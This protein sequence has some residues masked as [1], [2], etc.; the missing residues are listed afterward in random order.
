MASLKK[1]FVYNL[2]YQILIIILPLITAPYISRVLGAENVGVY[3]YTYSVANYFVLISM[4]GVKNYGNRSIARVRDDKE[5]LSKSFCNI[6]ALQIITSI[7]LGVIYILY[8]L[9]IAKENKIIALIQFFFV[10]TAI[11]DITWFFFGIEEFKITV[12]RNTVIKIVNVICILIFVKQRTDLWKYTLIMSLGMLL[13]YISVFPFLKRWVHFVKPSLKEIKSHFKP[14][15][16][17]FVPVL[18][19]SL[20]NIMDK[21]MLGNL[22]NMTQVGFYENTEKLMRIPFGVITALGTVM[23]PRMSNLVS[24][25]DRETGKKMINYSMVFIMFLANGMTFGLAGVGEIFAPIFFGNEF[26]ACGRLLMYIAPTILCL[27]WANVIRMQYLIPCGM[28]KE[29][30]ISTFVGA[31]VNMTINLILIPHYGAMGAIVGTVCAELSVTLYQTFAVRHYLPIKDLFKATYSFMIFGVVMF[32]I[33]YLIGEIMDSS[34]VT[35]FI[36]IFTGIIIY[37]IISFI[38]L[39]KS[40]QHIITNIRDNVLL[41]LKKR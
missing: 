40:R 30:T 35:L 10:L 16:I 31:G 6:Y 2:L 14:N 20:F 38:Y 7:I 25:G 24:N 27:S 21:I 5:E 17:L 18:A 33:V 1:N 41:K 15:L 4:L 22:S 26:S 32:L 9:F 34:I 3:S 28:D 8:V 23:L 11:T 12:T 36:Q 37:G 13:G 29:Y 19:V 39:M